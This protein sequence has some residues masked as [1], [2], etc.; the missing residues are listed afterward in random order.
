MDDAWP[1]ILLDRFILSHIIHTIKEKV[2][3]VP[4]LTKAAF[5]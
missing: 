2:G 1:F 5:D 3:L 4:S